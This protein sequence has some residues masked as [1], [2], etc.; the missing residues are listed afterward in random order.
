MKYVL[1]ILSLF[2]AFNPNGVCSSNTC[3]VEEYEINTE[4]K[5]HCHAEDDA[6]SEDIAHSADCQDHQE[7]NQHDCE[8]CMLTMVAPTST[9]IEFEDEGIAN[10]LPELQEDILHRFDFSIW[11][12]PNRFALS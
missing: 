5:D 7:D 12:P 9:A 8:Q 3:C 11:N 6:H 2:L 10:M 1:L 4:S